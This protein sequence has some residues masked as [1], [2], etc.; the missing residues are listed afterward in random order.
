MI[1]LLKYSSSKNIFIMQFTFNILNKN[2]KQSIFSDTAIFNS[3]FLI[4]SIENF[5]K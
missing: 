2:F 5:V 4:I 3:T 1:N